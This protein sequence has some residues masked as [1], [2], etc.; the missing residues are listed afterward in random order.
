MGTLAAALGDAIAILLPQHGIVTAGSD[1]PGAVMTAM[2]LDR[3]CRTQLDAI[4]AG[5]VRV[6]GQ[7]AGTVAKRADVWA[8]GQLRAGYEYLLRQVPSLPGAH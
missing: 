8:P 6:W 1:L 2:L 7:E 4:A 3:A 5:P